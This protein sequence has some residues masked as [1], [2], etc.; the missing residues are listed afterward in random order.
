MLAAN[1]SGCVSQLKTFERNHRFSNETQ[2]EHDDNHFVILTFLRIATECAITLS[3]QKQ[4]RVHTPHGI[5][6]LSVVFAWLYASF[7]S[8][9]LIS[10]QFSLSWNLQTIC[11]L[12]SFIFSFV[13]LLF[14]SSFAFHLLLIRRNIFILLWRWQ[15][16][17]NFSILQLAK[18]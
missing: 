13:L 16:H 5:V 6:I 2:N 14:A 8:R 10:W 7:S 17:H 12:L 3:W 15:C 1:I 11:S 18:L 4:I 9:K